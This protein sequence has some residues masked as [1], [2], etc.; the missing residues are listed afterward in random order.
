M[1]FKNN[2]ILLTAVFPE[3]MNTVYAQ[4]ENCILS[5]VRLRHR[6]SIFVVTND[7]SKIFR[8]IKNNKINLND[9]IIE[10]ISASK[11][12][13]LKGHKISDFKYT[14]A[15]I[16]SLRIFLEKKLEF[17]SIIISDIDCIFTKKIK[18]LVNKK[19][20]IF[21]ALNYY[22]DQENQKMHHIFSFFLRKYTSVFW[23]NS[24]F[25][26]FNRVDAKKILKKIDQYF[27]KFVKNGRFVKKTINHYGDE[28]LFS[29]AINF[30]KKKDLSN[31]V[32]L[33]TRIYVIAH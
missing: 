31:K 26:L 16:Q 15:K 20:I 3:G 8:I 25:M 14:F 10:N 2:Y 30:I 5:I 32:N 33:F 4:L 21:T 17:N 6:P 19:K 18:F 1:K 12:N 22:S 28:I 27:E 9:F 29:I 24:G 7:K 13:Y 23:I 11:K